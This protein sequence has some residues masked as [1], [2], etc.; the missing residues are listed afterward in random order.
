[1]KNILRRT[2]VIGAIVAVTTAVLGLIVYIPGFGA[3]GS[4]QEDFIP[5]APSTAISFIL[6]STLVVSLPYIQWEK[7]NI[8][9]GCTIALL[10]SIFGLLEVIGIFFDMDLNFEDVI[11]PSA[12][13]L[14]SIPVGRMSPS[15]GGVFFI[16]GIG[17]FGLIYFRFKETKSL[18]LM[19][20]A[21][22]L[23]SITMIISAIF[24]MAYIYGTPLLHGQET[25]IPMAMTTAFGFLMLGVS[26]FTSSEKT[27]FPLRYIAQPNTYA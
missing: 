7:R 2:A 14:G 23:G 18:K 11:F 25:L 4:V 9:I 1:M 17:I 13:T 8:I 26:I 21:G 3:L 15:T 16:A 5:M 22:S 27:S 6:L 19:H 24:L 10:V 20:W 12:G